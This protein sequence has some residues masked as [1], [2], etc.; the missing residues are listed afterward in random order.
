MSMEK[1]R[2]RMG[3]LG[4]DAIVAASPENFYYATGYPSFILYTGR[5]AGLA[6]AVIPRSEELEPV[7]I[8]N[9]FEIEGFRQHSR[10]ENVVTY[11][12]WVHIEDLRGASSPEALA[13]LGMPPEKGESVDL[14]GNFRMLAAALREM[15]LDKGV[16][17]VESLFIQRLPWALL[18]SSLPEAELTDATGLFYECRSIK[19]PE[20]IERLRL[21][22]R[23][24]EIGITASAG[25]IREGVTERDL[26]AAYRSAVAAEEG[27]R[28]AR[29]CIITVGEQFYPSF[30]QREAPA[31]AG[32]LIK[33]DVGADCGG[34]GSDIGRTFVVGRASALQEK[35]YAALRAGHD[36]AL[37]AIA[38]G[39]KMSEV[40]SAGQEAVRANGIP[41]YTRG[42]IGHSVGLDDRIEEA[43][44][45]APMEHRPLQ[46][47]MVLCVEM[48]YYAYGVGALQLED[49]VVI[50]DTGYEKLTSLCRDLVCV[51]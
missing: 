43:P 45:F 51:G 19:S 39:V 4:L 13:E 25:L 48:P 47:G 32:D 37:G 14:P 24:A 40:F 29:H 8:I 10:I 11:P 30:I 28:G 33:Y 36:A 50:T 18:E 23:V 9:E 5:V 44:N 27:C 31:E 20:E 42:H 17:G 12:M 16:I 2:E 3:E 46:P 1:L 34:Y 21:A 41:N 35:I 15:S 38:P 6:F 7:A 22:A 49:M 26:A